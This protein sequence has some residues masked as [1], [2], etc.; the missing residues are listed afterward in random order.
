MRE[1]PVSEVTETVARL[2][3]EANTD[4]GADVE[5]AFRRMKETEVSPTGKEVLDLLLKNA[6]IAREERMPICQ[7]TGLAVVFIDV[8]QDVHFTGGDLEG[9]IHEGVRRGYEKGY[10]RKSTCHPFTR[11][12]LGDN[13]PAI[14]HTH[15]VPGDRV[16]ITVEPKGGGSENMSR[17]VMLAPAEGVEGIKAYILQRV[18]ESG[19]N[20][21]PPIVVGVG[22]GGTFERA[23]LLAKKAT[24]RPIG[25]ENPDPELAA[26]EA[27][28]LEKINQIGIGPGGLGGKTTALAV[29]IEM[30]PCHIASLPLAVN[31][32]CHAGRHK[33]AVL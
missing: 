18:R 11:K 28:L 20:P 23:A 29:H 31:I 12:N 26:L 15:I 2:C 30:M 1:I 3:V 32:Q 21:C 16:R 24:L 22:I 7:D 13:T 19:S 14:I 6:R 8:G 5:E 4:L 9:A 33:E 10:L 17:V 25:T 27:E